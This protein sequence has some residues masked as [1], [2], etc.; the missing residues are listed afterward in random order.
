M[1]DKLPEWVMVPREPTDA[2]VNAARGFSVPG[3]CIAA[4]QWPS[5]Y[6]A[7]LAAAPQREVEVDEA[8]VERMAKNIVD[9]AYKIDGMN[10][11]VDMKSMH[12]ARAFALA[13]LTQPHGDNDA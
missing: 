10:L 8:M 1:S 3:Y 9:F 12:M 2:M 4:E 7:M 13:A 5:V 6:A 11:K